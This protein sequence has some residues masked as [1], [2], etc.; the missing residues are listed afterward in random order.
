MY[1]SSILEYTCDIQNATIAINMNEVTRNQFIGLQT[2]LIHIN[3]GIAQVADNNFSYN[4]MLTLNKIQKS[5]SDINRQYTR[6]LFPWEDYS[7]YESQ[8][9]GIFFFEFDQLEVP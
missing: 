1:S 7:F 2:T 3:G 9:K 4:G 6:S 5:V 8:E